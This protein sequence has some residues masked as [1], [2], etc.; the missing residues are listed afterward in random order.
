MHKF[1]QKK[2]THISPVLSRADS[3]LR[4]SHSHS[5]HKCWSVKFL[6][7]DTYSAYEL[8]IRSVHAYQ[9]FQ[10]GIVAMKR[11]WKPIPRIN[12]YVCIIESD[13]QPPACSLV[14]LLKFAGFEQY[15]CTVQRMIENKKNYLDLLWEW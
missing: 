15:M 12:Y 4:V 6:T 14:S 5:A 1:K 2:A 13:W 10:N 3:P 11:N 7:G 9:T 8:V